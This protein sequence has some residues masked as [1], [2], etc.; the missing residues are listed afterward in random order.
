MEVFELDLDWLDTRDV[1]IFLQAFF[2][3]G[4]MLFFL[5]QEI[6]LGDVMLEKMSADAIA[7]ACATS[8]D[9]VDFACISSASRCC[10]KDGKYDC[11]FLICDFRSIA[12]YRLS[13][14]CRCLD[15]TNPCYP[16][17][18]QFNRTARSI[19]Q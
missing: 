13:P 10:H 6:E 16:F 2:G 11:S 1:A 5:A 18:L 17:W 14:G 15:Q 7:D 19:L 3:F 12:T 4:K 9:D 8:G